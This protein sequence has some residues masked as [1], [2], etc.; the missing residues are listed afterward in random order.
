MRDPANYFGRTGLGP[1]VSYFRPSFRH[2]PNQSRVG[3]VWGSRT[4]NTPPCGPALKP[5]GELFRSKRSTIARC[6]V[7][8]P[9]WRNTEKTKGEDVCMIRDKHLPCPCV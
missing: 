7:G 3:V 6:M 1:F 4:Y 9:R 2:L 5:F 8:H